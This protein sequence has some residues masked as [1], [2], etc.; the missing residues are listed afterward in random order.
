MGP[1]RAALGVGLVSASLSACGFTPARIEDPERWDA[2]EVAA[3][4]G[5]EE[6]LRRNL[7][8]QDLFVTERRARGGLLD[9][10]DRVIGFDV[11]V[12][13]IAC[14]IGSVVVSLDDAGHL[15]DVY[16]RFGCRVA[17]LPSY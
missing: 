5:R 16:T 15:I 9:G 10:D 11:W 6:V 17:G 12:D 14:Q 1:I 4:I 3:A 2:R 7:V 8:I 13:V